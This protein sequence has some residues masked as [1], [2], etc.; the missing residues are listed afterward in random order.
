[1]AITLSISPHG[2]LFVEHAADNAVLDEVLSKRIEQAFAQGPAQ[3]ILHLATRQLQAN[4]PLDFAF[5]REFGD[6]YLTRLCHTPEIAG[7]T[8]FPPVPVPDAEEL[9]TI[10]ANAPPM[11]GLEYL[12]ADCLTAWWSELDKLVRQEVHSSGQGRRRICGSSIRSGGRL[13]GSRFIWRRTNATP[14]IRS[15]SW[16]RMRR[17]CRRRAGFSICRWG[18]R[19]RSMRGHKTARRCWH[20][21][22]RSSG[23]GSGPVDQGIG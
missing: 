22:N 2:R 4:L 13:G 5:A 19:C 14:K 6:R 18:G 16:R 7:A 23:P 3:G 11:R 10:T 20:C 9:A 1:M 12:N 17:S 8:E 21:C 15:H